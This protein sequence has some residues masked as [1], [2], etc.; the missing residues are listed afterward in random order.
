[1]RVY[2]TRDGGITTAGLENRRGP[3]V[4]CAGIY[5]QSQGRHCGASTIAGPE[6]QEYPGFDDPSRRWPPE[7]RRIPE[8]PIPLGFKSQVYQSP[9]ARSSRAA[10]PSAWH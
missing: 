8:H 3:W 7:S 9:I 4:A 5:D 6:R 2:S 10:I 1:L